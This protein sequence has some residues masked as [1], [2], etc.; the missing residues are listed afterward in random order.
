MSVLNE[1]TGPTICPACSNADVPRV[2]FLKRNNS[3]GAAESIINHT[4]DYECQTCFALF[5]VGNDI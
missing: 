3:I 1:L 2:G 5:E 4:V